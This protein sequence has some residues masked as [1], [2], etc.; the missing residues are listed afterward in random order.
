MNRLRLKLRQKTNSIAARSMRRVNKLHDWNANLL[1]KT[2]DMETAQRRARE[3][4]WYADKGDQTLRVQY[5]LGQNS[6][7]FDIGGYHGTWS[8]DIYCL[9]G[10]KIYIFEPVK[11]FVEVIKQTFGNNSDISVL[12]AGLSDKNQSAK[13]YVDEGA[14]STIKQ[15]G[16]PTT[17]KLIKASDFLKRNKIK[18]VD[19]MKINIE[20][21][22]YALLNHLYGIGFLKNVKDIQVQ[23][24]NFTPT[25]EED[26]KAIQKKLSETHKLTY[27]Y[28]WV[29]DNW[30]RKDS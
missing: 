25:A 27:Q 8:R 7:V 22:E 13:I 30:S 21:G 19:L 4:K 23:F 26:M 12:T 24:H 16:T 20:G 1:I 14:S 10:S 17:V 18:R 29:W 28:P 9:Y 2:E 6:I 5:P 11:S 3:A 15:A